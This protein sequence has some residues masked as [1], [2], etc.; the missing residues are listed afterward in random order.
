M[1]LFGNIAFIFPFY[2]DVSHFVFSHG[3]PGWNAQYLLI[4]IR[5]NGP[6]HSYVLHILK[7]FHTFF[8]IITFHVMDLRRFSS[9]LRD[10][11]AGGECLVLFVEKLAF[12]SK[13]MGAHTH[14]QSQAA[15]N[16]LSFQKNPV[17]SSGLTSFLR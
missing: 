7:Y 2:S 12:S 9:G 11:C 13:H 5:S 1:L 14:L 3:S 4:F 10:G 16:N 6:G 17:P 15:N 8:L